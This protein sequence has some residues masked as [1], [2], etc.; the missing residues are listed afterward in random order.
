MWRD[1]VCEG[2]ITFGYGMGKLYWL[3]W[4][5]VVV[6]DVCVST[7]V[8]CFLGMVLLLI[9]ATQ[10][11]HTPGCLPKVADLCLDCPPLHRVQDGIQVHCALIRH[12]KKN[13]VGL[14]GTGPTLL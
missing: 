12:M 1:T 9:V 5:M 6:D 10:S 13:V 14:L 2:S 11:A 4:M 8:P 3:L 7:T